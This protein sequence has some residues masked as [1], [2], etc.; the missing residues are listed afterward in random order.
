[1]RRFGCVALL[2]MESGKGA[3]DREML[4]LV[5]VHVEK[6]CT[7]MSTSYSYLRKLKSI[8]FTLQVTGTKYSGESL[9]RHLF[10]QK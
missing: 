4:V 2:C 9:A 10:T 7:S 8:L 5:H 6:V 3:L 1:M